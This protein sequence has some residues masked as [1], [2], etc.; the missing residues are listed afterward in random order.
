MEYCYKNSENT[1]SLYCGADSSARSRTD[2]QWHYW[3]YIYDG[4]YC[5]LYCDGVCVSYYDGYTHTLNSNN[6]DL[7]IEAKCII[8]ELRISNNARSADEINSYYKTAKPI[9]DSNTGSLEAIVY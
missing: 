5:A 9:L 3:A 6:N 4:T 1:S 7:Q 8:D 2:D